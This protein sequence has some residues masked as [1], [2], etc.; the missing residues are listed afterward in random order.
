MA[1]VK[2]PK[3]VPCELSTC[4]RTVRPDNPTFPYCVYHSS[5][6]NPSES[7]LQKLAQRNMTEAREVLYNPRKTILSNREASVSMISSRTGMKSKDVDGIVG[8]WYEEAEGKNMFN[9][10]SAREHRAELLGSLM[11]YL[12]KKFFNVKPVKC[13]NSYAPTPD[14]KGTKR[15]QDGH[16]VI[17]FTMTESYES[18]S[19]MIADPAPAAQLAGVYSGDVR[20]TYGKWSSTLSDGIHIA[21][22][23]EYASY[24]SVEHGTIKTGDGEVIWESQTE[25][26]E[27]KDIAEQKTIIESNPRQVFDKPVYKRSPQVDLLK[28]EDDGL[29]ELFDD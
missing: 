12:G 3:A 6:K 18:S 13:E 20:Q 7:P 23:V 9:P 29:D 22:L 28:T 2:A 24:S 19:I 15:L 16:E 17:S 26:F 10:E 21:S 25:V 8:K 11:D 14:R 4:N 1:R 5:L 27:R